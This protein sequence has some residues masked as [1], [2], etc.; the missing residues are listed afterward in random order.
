MCSS[1]ALSSRWAWRTSA[2]GPPPAT[3][4]SLLFMALGLRGGIELALN[5]ALSFYSHAEVLVSFGLLDHPLAGALRPPRP[6]A[7]IGAGL[8]AG[9]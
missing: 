2:I 9:F 6:S 5:D 8:L 7:S 1:H 4:V 3:D